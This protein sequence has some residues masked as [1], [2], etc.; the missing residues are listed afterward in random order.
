MRVDG[1]FLGSLDFAPNLGTGNVLEGEIAKNTALAVTLADGVLRNQ[2]DV[3]QSD[4][5]PCP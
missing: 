2:A 4:D 5:H 1:G 3:T